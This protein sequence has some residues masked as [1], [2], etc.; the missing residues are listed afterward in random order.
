MEKQ[1][2][3]M[4]FFFGKKCIKK[5]TYPSCMNVDWT[6]LMDTLK[7]KNKQKKNNAS[8]RLL[9][10]HRGVFEPERQNSLCELRHGSRVPLLASQ[11]LS[12]QTCTNENKHIPAC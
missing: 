6:H 2:I 8:R 3:F 10:N 12:A 1:M 11:T 9:T 5:E 4:I 7:C